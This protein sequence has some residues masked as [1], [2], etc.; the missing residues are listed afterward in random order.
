[1]QLKGDLKAEEQWRKSSETRL[2]ELQ[3]ENEQLDKD[4]KAAR[5]LADMNWLDAAIAL[6]EVRACQAAEKAEPEPNRSK[7]ISQNK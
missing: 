7:Q 2:A 4:V 3:R 1:M 5:G 6:R